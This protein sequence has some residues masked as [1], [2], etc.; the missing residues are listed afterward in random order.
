MKQHATA[1][2]KEPNMPEPIPPPIAACPWCGP[3]G[4]LL[5]ELVERSRDRLG[6]ALAQKTKAQP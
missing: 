5:V 2:T 3:N 6:G 4:G 1:D